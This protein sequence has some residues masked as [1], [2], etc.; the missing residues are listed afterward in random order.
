MVELLNENPNFL[1]ENR[2]SGKIYVMIWPWAVTSKVYLKVIIFMYHAVI[3]VSWNEMFN[4]NVQLKCFRI[5]LDLTLTMACKV[6]SIFKREA[7]ILTQEIDKAEYFR[8]HIWSLSFCCS[9][10][11]GTSCIYSMTKKKI[12]F[13]RTE[14]YRKT[15]PSRFH[16]DHGIP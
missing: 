13:C 9:G 11:F 5:L 6:M 14:R 4:S 12:F 1:H 16:N 8:L 15:K 3:T 2:K 7:I 10:S